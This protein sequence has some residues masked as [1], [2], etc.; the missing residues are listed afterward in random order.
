MLGAGTVQDFLLGR[1]LAGNG[2]GT[3]DRSRACSVGPKGPGPGQI[4]LHYPQQ[5]HQG[6]VRDGGVIGCEEVGRP[7]EPSPADM[8]ISL[9]RGA[10][11]SNELTKLANNFAVLGS[12]P[13]CLSAA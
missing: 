8:P 12:P 1:A 9:E 4:N 7:H 3:P 6:P 11:F 10:Q 2:L 5:I 13:P